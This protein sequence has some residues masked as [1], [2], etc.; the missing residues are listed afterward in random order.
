MGFG[1]DE[2]RGAIFI[3]SWQRYIPSHGFTIAGGDF[4]RLAKVLF[5]R[6]LHF[7][8]PPHLSTLSSLDGS[9]HVQCTLQDTDS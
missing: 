2:G 9:Q 7:H 3:T 8:C 6:F 4:D 5:V 1:E